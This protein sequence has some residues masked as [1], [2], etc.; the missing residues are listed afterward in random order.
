MRGSNNI[1][2]AAVIKILARQL[3]YVAGEN[4]RHIFE[5]EGQPAEKDYPQ[6]SE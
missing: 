2:M 6:Q 1:A 5:E 3:K 4:E